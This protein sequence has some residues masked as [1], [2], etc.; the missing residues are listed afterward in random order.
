MNG[1]AMR[2]HSCL[3]LTG[4]LPRRYPKDPVVPSCPRVVGGI[5]Q[6]SYTRGNHAKTHQN[7]D[8]VL[9]MAAGGGPFQM[10]LFML[11]SSG[12]QAARDPACS[13]L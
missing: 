8:A 6:P 4:L 7:R 5:Y 13:L 2:L 9:P 12:K 10:P 11:Q 3:R 1:F